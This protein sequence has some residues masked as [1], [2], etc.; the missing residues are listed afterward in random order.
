MIHVFSLHSYL[1]VSAEADEKLQTAASTTNNPN[2]FIFDLIRKMSS[3]WF[4]LS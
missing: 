3:V 2:L 4:A 1:H